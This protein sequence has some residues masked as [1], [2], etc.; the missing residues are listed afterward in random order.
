M[1]HGHHDRLA[2]YRLLADVAGLSSEAAA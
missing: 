1:V 2:S